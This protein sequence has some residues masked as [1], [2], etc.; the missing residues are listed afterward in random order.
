MVRSS[1]DPNDASSEFFILADD[2]D[3]SSPIARELD[4]SFAPFGF[5]LEGAERLPQ[6]RAGCRVPDRVDTR[7]VGRL[8]RAPCR[9]QPDV[10]APRRRQQQARLP[11]ARRRGPRR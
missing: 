7:R 4:G 6:L 1:A 10:P 8:E 9:L 3:D 5:I 11:D 2:L